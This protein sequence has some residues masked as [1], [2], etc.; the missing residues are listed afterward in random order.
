MPLHYPFVCLHS[1]GLNTSAGSNLVKFNL[2][3]LAVDTVHNSDQTL[4]LEVRYNKDDVIYT[5]DITINLQRTD[6]DKPQLIVEARTN[7]P[8]SALSAGLVNTY[9][10]GPVTGERDY[11]VGGL[12]TLMNK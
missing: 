3:L 6:A 9:L 1:V 5:Q 2:T 4:E 8:T 10:G 12:S 7:C 11:Y